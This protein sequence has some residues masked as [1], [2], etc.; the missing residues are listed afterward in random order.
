MGTTA[1]T[2]PVPPIPLATPY[3]P[4]MPPIPVKVGGIPGTETQRTH[5]TPAGT[6]LM[7]Y[8]TEVDKPNLQ[9]KVMGITVTLAV[10][11]MHIF[12]LTITGAP[13][14]QGLTNVVVPG[15]LSPVTLKATLITALGIA[16]MGL[17]KD[18]TTIFQKLEGRYTLLDR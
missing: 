3:H 18:L 7:A 12:L 17:L 16:T 9:A 4:A 8:T 1:G 6:T 10:R 2:I 15:T 5:P 11:F 13:A 14:A